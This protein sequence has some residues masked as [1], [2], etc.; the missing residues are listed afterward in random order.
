VRAVAARVP[1]PVADYVR[2]QIRAVRA[3]RTA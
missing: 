2:L 1:G 3:P